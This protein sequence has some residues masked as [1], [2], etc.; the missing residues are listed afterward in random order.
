M[1]KEMNVDTLPV[2][3]AYEVKGNTTHE[4]VAGRRR[5][6]TVQSGTTVDTV[7]SEVDPEI[8]LNDLEV[9]D[10]PVLLLRKK[11]SN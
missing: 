9:S 4:R 3:V 5:S 6:S 10:S 11:M 1:Q 8:L 7:E 2:A